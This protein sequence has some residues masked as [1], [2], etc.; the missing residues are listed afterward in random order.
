VVAGAET[1]NRGVEGHHDLRVLI[2][3]GI[4]IKAAIDGQAVLQERGEPTWVGASARGR[5]HGT[6]GMKKI[7]AHG[8]D[9]R[10]AQHDADG[11]SRGHT[12]VAEIAARAW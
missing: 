9:R 5:D 6:A 10:L 8:I 12:K 1:L 3:G 2:S 4:G 11:R 7:T